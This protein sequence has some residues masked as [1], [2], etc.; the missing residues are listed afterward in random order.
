MEIVAWIGSVLL[1]LCGL[2]IAIEAIREK[3]SD[4]NLLFLL[5]WG[6]GEILTLI[7]VIYKK[8]GALTFNYMTNLVFILIVLWYRFK[9]KKNE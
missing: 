7:Y 8:E 1:A 2:P 5:M 6:G 4:I 3:K 9:G